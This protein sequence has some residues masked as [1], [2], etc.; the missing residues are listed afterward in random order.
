[1]HRTDVLWGAVGVF[2]VMLVFAW[3]L[4]ADTY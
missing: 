4:Q 3:M 2:V 1:V